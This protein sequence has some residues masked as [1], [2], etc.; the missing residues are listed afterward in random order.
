MSRGVLRVDVEGRVGEL[1]RFLAHNS[2]IRSAFDMAL[3]D[4]AGKAANLLRAHHDKNRDGRLD[5]VAGNF[6]Q[7]NRLYLNDGGTGF[8]PPVSFNIGNATSVAVI[9]ADGNGSPDV[10]V[11]NEDA[12]A[13]DEK[14]GDAD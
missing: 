3:Y 1:T 13:G 7:P 4:L 12:K 11:V 6:D 8:L 10:A 9:R 2:A 5:V 14:K